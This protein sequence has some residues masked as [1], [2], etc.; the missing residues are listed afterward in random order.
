MENLL[1]S[2]PFHST[3]PSCFVL[4]SEHVKPA[5]SAAVSL[6]IIDLS[7][8]H[9]EVCRSILAA[10]RDFG[11]FQAS[12]FVPW[13]S[14]STYTLLYSHQERNKLVVNVVGGQP[15]RLQAGDA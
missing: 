2:T 10:G 15:W 6:P 3:V 7:G 4:P 13:I 1:H 9:D 14:K 11:F 12:A 8:S 5:T